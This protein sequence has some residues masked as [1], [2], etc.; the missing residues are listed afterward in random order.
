MAKNKQSAIM[1]NPQV[2]RFRNKILPQFTKNNDVLLALG[3]LLVLGLL[4][5]PLPPLMLDFFLA[6]NISISVL[7]ILVSLYL[8]TPLEF[9]SFPTILLITTL[10]RLGLNVATTRLIL[11]EAHAGNIIK[12]FG[13]F[14]IQGNYVVGFIIF[15]ILMVINFVVI[16]KGSTRIAEVTARFTLDALPGKQMSIDAD[17]NAGYIDEGTAKERREKLTAE[18]DFFGAM[19]G[20]AKFIKGDAIA[21]I[22]ITFVNILGGFA[23][24]M[25]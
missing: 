12:A 22:I 20:A 5:I 8:R 2:Q 3:V 6:A 21:G 17:L 14:V 11:G 13:D 19:D 9:S 24:G 25:L 7:I 10:F 4:I 15:I 23:I 18:A 1:N 16:I